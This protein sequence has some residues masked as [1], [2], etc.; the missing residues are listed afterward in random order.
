MII[1]E[2]N[3]VLTL[4]SGKIAM[5]ILAVAAAMMLACTIDYEV[6]SE[7][8]FIASVHAGYFE[9]EHIY[10]INKVHNDE[11]YITYGFR[12]NDDCGGKFTAKYRQQLENSI[13]EIIKVWL[14][15]ILIKGN[16]VNKFRYAMKDIDLEAYRPQIKYQEEEEYADIAFIFYCLGADNIDRSV[17]TTQVLDNGKRIHGVVRMRAYSLVNFPA[18]TL[19]DLDMYVSSI[20]L[21]E[22]GHAFGLGDT[23]L[24]PSRGESRGGHPTTLGSQ[25]ESVMANSAHRL[26]VDTHGNLKLGIDDSN[27]IKW[28]YRYYVEKSI[29]IDECPAGYKRKVNEA[30]CVPKYPLIFEIK[31]GWDAYHI[32]VILE[33]DP[34]IDINARDDLGLYALHYAARAS[35][36]DVVKAILSKQYRRTDWHNYWRDSIEVNVTSMN[37][38][39][40]LHIAARNSRAAVLR[41]LLAHPHVD[42]SIVNKEG[43]TAYDYA[44]ASETLAAEKDI[45]ARL[46]VDSLKYE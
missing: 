7:A 44:I 8:K 12:D 39:T 28:L 43:K 23:Y 19:T 37:G 32:N 40:A 21:H 13:T 38:D 33:H 46:R 3:A 9:P 29:R 34:N 45:I 36:V 35:E 31:Q 41:V 42:V 11:L 15:P 4:T 16:I 10:L 22:V 27:G 24:V 5:K 20:V 25:P 18:P 14:R 2:S 30:G 1:Y 17:W 26:G 6:E